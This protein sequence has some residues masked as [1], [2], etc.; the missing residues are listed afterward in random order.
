MSRARNERLFV[1]FPYMQNTCQTIT[2]SSFGQVINVPEYQWQFICLTVGRKHCTGWRVNTYGPSFACTRS[3]VMYVCHLCE[4]KIFATTCDFCFAWHTCLFLSVWMAGVREREKQDMV[5]CIIRELK[6][7]WY[8]TVCLKCI[9]I[10]DDKHKDWYLLLLFLLL[11]QLWVYVSDGKESQ[12]IESSSFPSYSS[13]FKGV[14][15]GR[16]SI[17]CQTLK[18]LQYKVSV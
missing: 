12:R 15:P 17:L 16:C 8:L 7:L 13:F 6:D 3:L 4:R 11:F 9:C 14:H 2:Y 10:S 18:G 1:R 5:W